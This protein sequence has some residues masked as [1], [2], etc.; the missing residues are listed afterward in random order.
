MSNSA[1]I[2]RTVEVRRA[3]LAGLMAA[4]AAA[5][6]AV[7]LAVTLAVDGRSTGTTSSGHASPSPA[8]SAPAGADRGA[9]SLM[10]FTPAQLLAGTLGGYALPATDRPTL[11]SVLS[12]MSPK[13]RSYT[14]RIMGLTFEQL[15]AGA[16]G[17][18]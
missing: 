8:V 10:S 2:P 7:T 5:A 11:E 18:P 3:S 1:S 12:S 6:A 14:E 16:A 15:A 17:Q 13:T 9:V 4:T